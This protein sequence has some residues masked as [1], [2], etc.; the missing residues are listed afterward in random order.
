MVAIAETAEALLPAASPRLLR[1]RQLLSGAR[2]DAAAYFGSFARWMPFRLGESKAD[3]SIPYVLA[4]ELVESS[5][6][7]AQEFLALVKRRKEGEPAREMAMYLESQPKRLPPWRLFPGRLGEGS[8]LASVAARALRM[9]PLLDAGLVEA[10]L[11]RGTAANLFVEQLHAL[12]SQALEADL[13]SGVDLPYLYVLTL[14]ASSLV[15][16]LKQHAKAAQIRGVS[17]DRL[18]KALGFLYYVTIDELFDRLLQPLPGRGLPFETESYALRVRVA[19]NPLAF[20]SIRKSVLF[21]DLNPYAI[22]TPW[23]ATLEPLFADLMGPNAD[24][25][26]IE[27]RLQKLILSESGLADAAVAQGRL[28]HMREAVLSFL[29]RFDAYDANVTA[30]LVASA[31]RDEDLAQL[32][33][34]SKEILA[35]VAPLSH[36]RLGPHEAAALQHLREALTGEVDR[37][38]LVSFATIGFI[39]SSLDRLVV[40]QLDQARARLRDRRTELSPQRRQQEYDQGTLYRFAADG[41]PFLRS[42]NRS[43]QGH[44]FI[45]LKGFTQRTYRAKEVVM[46]EFMRSE[47]YAP[48]LRAA[49]AH[50]ATPGPDGQPALTLQNLLGDAA[51]FSGDVR[52]LVRLARDIQQHLAGYAE[53]LRVRMGPVAAEAEQRMMTVR[54]EADDAILKLQTEQSM[55]DAELARKRSLTPAAQE[56]LLWDLY[57]RRAFAL[58]KRRTD[59]ELSGAGAEA[60]RLLRAESQLQQERAALTE[61]L[62]VLTGSERQAHID[63]RICAPERIRRGE[64]Q[65]ELASAAENTRVMLRALEDEARSASGFGLEAGLFVTYGAAAERVELDDPAFGAVRVAI[66]E[67]IN[68]AARGTARSAPIRAKLEALLERARTRKPS[69][70][71]PFFV[72]VDQTYSFVFSPELTSLVDAAIAKKDPTQAAELSRMLAEGVQHDVARMMG[73]PDP[74]APGL[75]TV[76]NDIYNVGEAFSEEALEAFLRETRSTR[77]AFRRGLSAAELHPDFRERFLFTDDAIQL[78]ISLPLSGDLADTLIFRL[79]GH[80]H[81]RGFEAK[82]A[83]AVYELLRPNS[84]FVKLLAHHHLRTWVSDARS[85]AAMG[86]P[87]SNPG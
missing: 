37:A 20:C 80:V 66:A 54:A 27:T 55:L 6:V 42:A 79:A 51:V 57:A 44:L 52:A 50:L 73:K 70:E 3:A 87:G 25:R 65:R 26:G 46:A 59:A 78:C 58:E 24:P 11:S 69:M 33:R 85:G 61:S 15:E 49:R 30:A 75:L 45:D 10:W 13:N 77:F 17:Y 60:E 36:R 18:E 32:P 35:A 56:E 28:A 82:R 47:F 81:F 14:A 29:T 43:N 4:D 19:L 21:N 76:L 34:Q 16:D 83:T 7:A 12:A 63:E 31:S 67:K 5:Q 64:I 9:D 68:E 72:Y 22:S 62:E 71:L 1:Y 39:A 38:R 84:G 48:I 74:A 8:Y 86:R 41:L 23:A 53:K 2:F 40:D